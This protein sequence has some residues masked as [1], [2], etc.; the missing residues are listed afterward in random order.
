M[1]LLR[2]LNSNYLINL[3]VYLLRLLCQ[4]SFPSFQ[5]SLAL[6]GRQK[7]VLDSLQRLKHVWG[8]ASTRP[9]VTIGSFLDE[10][11]MLASHLWVPSAGKIV[12]VTSLTTFQDTQTPLCIRCSLLKVA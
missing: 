3:L 4:L 1:V 10:Q 8:S 5:L 2:C 6:F 7:Q 12:K 11:N 9:C